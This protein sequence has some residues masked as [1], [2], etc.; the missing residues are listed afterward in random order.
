M[1]PRIAFVT[2]G[3][4]GIGSVICCKLSGDEFD[5]AL[6]YVSSETRARAIQDEIESRG[7]QTGSAYP[8]LRS[9]SRGEA[10]SQLCD[11]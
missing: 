10:Q 6:T 2:G 3:G 5:I 9:Y 11:N 7:R 8:G 1:T 4:R